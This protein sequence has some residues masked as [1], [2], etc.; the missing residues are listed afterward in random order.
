MPGNWLQVVTKDELLVR[1][2]T[3]AQLR[4]NLYYHPTTDEQWRF[5]VLMQAELNARESE[6][7]AMTVTA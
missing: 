7:L 2:L 4:D 6:M 1:S 5:R 3:Y